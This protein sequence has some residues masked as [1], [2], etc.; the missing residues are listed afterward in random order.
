[1]TEKTVPARRE[2]TKRA[3]VNGRNVLTVQ[4]KEPGYS[5]R[6]VNDLG[7][8]VDEF[9]ARGY[10][11]V[12]DKD[13]QIG[14]RRVSAPS[15]LGS[16]ASAVVDKQGTRA[17]VMRQREEWYLE[18]QAEKAKA[19][20]ETEQSMEQQALSSNEYGKLDITRS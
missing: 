2:R 17:L 8:R 14:D 11:I 19:I 16:K 5:Y 7:G 10:E 20:A 4:N 6:F 12:E 13:V 18:D 3:P 1:M 9:L 15:G